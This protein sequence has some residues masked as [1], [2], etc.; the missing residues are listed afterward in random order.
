MR[1]ERQGEWEPG[2]WE[3]GHLD[4]LGAGH[5]LLPVGR[6]LSGPAGV[7]YRDLLVDGLVFVRHVLPSTKTVSVAPRVGF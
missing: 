6:A 2:E 7:E 5:V 1:G 4:A 3:W